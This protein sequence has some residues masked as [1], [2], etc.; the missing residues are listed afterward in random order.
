[1]TDGLPRTMSADEKL[2][3]WHNA[4]AALDLDL[5][6]FEWDSVNERPTLIAW[7]FRGEDWVAAPA[8]Y[9]SRPSTSKAPTNTH[10]LL[11]VQR[12]GNVG[13]RFT[14]VYIHEDPVR[15]CRAIHTAITGA[16]LNNRTAGTA[17]R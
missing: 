2:V 8:D 4:M 13:G 14:S 1:M 9:Q 3:A 15:V 16:W 10:R 6:G 12:A 5:T 11:N 17:G 7:R